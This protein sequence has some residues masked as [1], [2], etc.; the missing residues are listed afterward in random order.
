[1]KIREIER[2]SKSYE[3]YNGECLWEIVQ[4]VTLNRLMRV[5]YGKDDYRER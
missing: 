5:I 2:T 3:A 4:R 1:M